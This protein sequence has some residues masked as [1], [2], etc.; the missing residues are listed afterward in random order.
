MVSPLN[1]PPARHDTVIAPDQ[2]VSLLIG[3]DYVELR[4]FGGPP[5]DLPF[6]VPAVQ[7]FSPDESDG[8]SRKAFR[9]FQML[10]WPSLLV[11]VAAICI[12]AFWAGSLG[13]P[14]RGGGKSN[15]WAA[16]SVGAN[17]VV[18]TAGSVTVVVPVGGVLPS[19]EILRG[20]DELRQ[21]FSTDTQTTAVKK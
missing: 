17:T 1:A 21:N 10:W 4:G 6:W 3:A 15:A 13:S 7:N 9:F 18:M 20:V 8:A 19:G 12:V 14:A 16:K 2:L 11:G 5:A